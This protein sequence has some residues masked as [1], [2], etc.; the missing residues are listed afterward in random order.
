V[1]SIADLSQIQNRSGDRKAAVEMSF[2]A[3]DSDRAE[4]KQ[5]FRQLQRIR[6][7]RAEIAEPER[8][9]SLC[10]QAAEAL[11]PGKDQKRA[12]DLQEHAIRSAQEAARRAQAQ[13]WHAV[14]PSESLKRQQGHGRGLSMEM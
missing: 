3:S 6:A 5:L 4:V 9:V 14:D 8:V 2:D 1:E 13:K 12:A 10:R 11:E 7:V